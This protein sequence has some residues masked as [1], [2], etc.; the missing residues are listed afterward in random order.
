MGCHCLLRLSYGFLQV[1][2]QEWD[3]QIIVSFIKKPLYCFPW[4]L[5]QFTFPSAVQKGL[6]C[7]M[8]SPA[9]I[10]YR[11]FD[12]GH[13]DQCEMVP[14]CSFDLH[15]SII[16]SEVELPFM[17]LLAICMSSLEKCVFRSSAH[18]LI[19][20]LVLLV[21]SCMSCLYILEINFLLVASFANI[22]SHSEGCFC[23]L[24]MVSFVVQKLLSPIC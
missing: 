18:F 15:Y 3:C 9:F 5:H 13:C 14:H 11:L 23:I 4:W 21:L 19:R 22:F 10:V 2:A 16:S 6:L 20:L 8:P 17:C 7:S 1:Y 24:F 12:N